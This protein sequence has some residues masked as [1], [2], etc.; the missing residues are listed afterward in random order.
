[1]LEPAFE[2]IGSVSNGQ[3]LFDKAMQIKPDGVVTDIS[4][5][6]LNGIEAACNK[7]IGLRVEI[8][9]LSIHST[10]TSCELS[11]NRYLVCH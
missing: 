6:I 10:L 5:P 4:M 1:M 2:I 8:V 3:S 9:F 7:E 11:V